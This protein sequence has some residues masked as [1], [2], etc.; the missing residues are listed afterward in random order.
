MDDQA[1]LDAWIDALAPTLGLHITASQRPGVRGFL[2]IAAAMAAELE[3]VDLADDALDLAP[4]FT[5]E[6]PA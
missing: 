3:G 4:V 6:P 5:P 2:A 1:R